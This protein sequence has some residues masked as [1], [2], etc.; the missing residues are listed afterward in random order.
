MVKRDAERTKKQDIRG[1][2]YLI[3]AVTQGDGSLGRKKI[4]TE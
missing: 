4:L 3:I 1:V 2:I